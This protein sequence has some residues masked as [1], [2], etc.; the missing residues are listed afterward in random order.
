MPR[1]GPALH[2]V[3]L[4]PAKAGYMAL[5]LVLACFHLLPW[6]NVVGLARHGCTRAHV[7]VRAP[8]P[9]IGIGIAWFVGLVM[10]AGNARSSGNMPS[11]T[12]SRFR[13]RQPAPAHS[14]VLGVA[15]GRAR[16]GM[17]LASQL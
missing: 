2:Q 12:L 15:A 5:T 14:V 16:A 1:H 6:R 11:L 13:R 4:S 7:L 8:A 9:Q 3:H 17:L 10:D